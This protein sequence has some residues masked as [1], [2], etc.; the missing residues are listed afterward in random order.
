MRFGSRAYECSLGLGFGL[1]VLR[2]WLM[3]RV[4]GLLALRASGAKCLAYGGWLAGCHAVLT[5]ALGSPKGFVGT[6]VSYYLRLK[7]WAPNMGP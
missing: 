3:V 7:V 5:W 1:E 6:Y 2:V 4:E